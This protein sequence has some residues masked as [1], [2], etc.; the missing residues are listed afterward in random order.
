M[1]NRAG[2]VLADTSVWIEFFKNKSDAGKRLE[3]LISGGI[4]FVCGIVMFELLQGVKSETERAA[5][6]SALSGLPHIEMSASLWEKSAQI[7]AS[8]KKDGL[9][10]PLSD[11]FIAALAMEHN[12]AVFTLDKHFEKIPGVKIYK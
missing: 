8:L 3:G 1:G 11:I 2:G 5:I 7:S 10:I 6:K 12:L 4:V 9:T